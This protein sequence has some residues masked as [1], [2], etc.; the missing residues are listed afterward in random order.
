MIVEENVVYTPTLDYS[1]VD[2]FTYTV[3][4]GR[5]PATALVTVTV[6]PVNDPPVMGDVSLGPQEIEIGQAITLTGVFSDPDLLDQHTLLVEWVSGV[7]E[8]IALE[9][10]ARFFS[11]EHVYAIPGEFTVTIT[12]QD[13]EGLQASLSLEVTVR[14]VWYKIH[15]PIII[16]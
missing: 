1:G 2:V 9:A 4:N 6:L 5:L 3:T 7:T 16:K 10:G 15:F 12:I 8:T 11:L 13:L 14:Q